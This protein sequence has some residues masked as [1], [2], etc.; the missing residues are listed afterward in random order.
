MTWVLRWI[1]SYNE[2]YKV[3]HT[4]TVWIWNSIFDLCLNI[5]EYKPDGT[6]SSKLIKSLSV[7]Q[8][9]W[10][11]QGHQESYSCKPTYNRKMACKI[12]VLCFIL[13]TVCWVEAEPE[14]PPSVFDDTI[15]RLGRTS[16]PVLPLNLSSLHLNFSSLH[17][18]HLNFNFSGLHLN[19]SALQHLHLR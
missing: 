19:L 7:G 10:L 18:P 8:K 6:P 5:P 4:K 2:A 17:F 11:E 12:S 16:S 1:G 15:A 3:K 14:D 13:A 9:M